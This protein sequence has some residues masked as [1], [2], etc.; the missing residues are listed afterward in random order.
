MRPLVLIH[1]FTGSPASFDLVVDELDEVRQVLVP[2]LFGHDGTSGPETVKTFRDEVDRLAAAIAEW[3]SEPTFLVGYSLGARVALGLLTH[4]PGLSSGAALIG[5]NPGIDDPDERRSRAAADDR[6]RAVLDRGDLQGFINA[7]GA[8]TLFDTQQALPAEV[9]ERQN[10]ERLNH[11]AGGLSRSLAVMGL[12]AMP[13]YRGALG[14]IRQPIDLLVGERDTKFRTLAS[15]INDLLPA[16]SLHVAAGAGHNLLLEAP[17]E[18]ARII[19]KGIE[20]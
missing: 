14:K 19:R 17:D 11:S 7:W 9:L 20:P 5:V 16:G 3:A 8:Q 1:G 6:W 13:S 4:H 18:V 10:N 12:A 2:T 15:E